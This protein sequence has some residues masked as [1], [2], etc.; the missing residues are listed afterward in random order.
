MGLRPIYTPEL[1]RRLDARGGRPGM[2]NLTGRDVSGLDLS[3]LPVD[4][5]DRAS[6]RI[7][8]EVKFGIKKRKPAM[9]GSLDLGELILRDCAFCGVVFEATNFRGS[10]LDKCD[11]RYAQ[12]SRATLQDTQIV[13]CD[14]YRAFFQDGTIFDPAVLEGTSFTRAYLAGIVELQRANLRRTPWNSKRPLA[15]ELSAERYADF[16]T[17]TLPDRFERESDEKLKP[18]ERSNRADDLTRT[19]NDRHE[20]AAIVLRRIAALWTSQGAYAFAGWAYVRGKRKERR[21]VSPLKRT[22]CALVSDNGR[23][24]ASTIRARRRVYVSARVEGRRWAPRTIVRRARIR[25]QFNNEETKKEGHSFQIRLA[26]RVR[27]RA[28]WVLLLAADAVCAFGEG[29]GHVVFWVGALICIPGVVYWATH[30]V[31]ETAT[32]RA[33]GLGDSMLFALTELVNSSPGR[34]H[35]GTSTVETFTAIQT[36]LGIILLGLLGFV[37]GNKLHSS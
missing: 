33:A 7:L 2:I 26:R 28:R 25:H 30:S 29:L 1:L 11:F 31:E 21:Q 3:R 22:Y 18:D 35:A 12:F 8:R 15:Q 16:L 10:R 19:I 20:E 17:A 24:T 32:K 27:E 36:L 37:L 13:S 5:G 6:R 9:I 34:L 23:I 14:F 4:A